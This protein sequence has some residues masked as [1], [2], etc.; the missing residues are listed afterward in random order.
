MTKILPNTFQTPNSYI[1]RAM[2]H[3]TDSELRC[4][5]FATRH[6][7]G[8]Q[9]KMTKRTARI[10]LSFFEQGYT[11][12][13]GTVYAGTGLNRAAIIKALEALVKYGFL[14]RVGKP[15]T[16]GQ[17]WRLNDTPHWDALEQRSAARQER[18]N[19]QTHPATR[20][21]QQ[22]RTGTLNDTS[23]VER[24][25]GTSNVPVSL[26]VPDRYVERTASG[27]SN[28]TESKP[29]QSQYKKNKNMSASDDAA[30]PAVT[31][32]SSTATHDD[33]TAATQPTNHMDADGSADTAPAPKRARPRNPL[34]DAIAET[35]GTT[36]GGW[37]GNM[38]S[39]MAGKGKANSAWAAC[40]FDPPA[41]PDEVRAFGVWA[42]A[43]N[44]DGQLPT[45]PA[46]IQRQFYA[47]RQ[48]QQA[49]APVRS[50]QLDFEAAKAAALLAER[51]S[52]LRVVSA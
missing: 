50:A 1:D 43:R 52:W 5:L 15:T 7:M 24:T 41:T 32:A 19:H 38:A 48:Q 16:A 9:D 17:Q 40:A 49:P 37:V 4:L 31:V 35:W 46:T 36:A 44:P 11:A 47:F 30:A 42:R 6:I 3:L 10:S 8:W 34:F 51:R 22:K 18:R 14:K 12:D 2:P 27:T 39:M 33:A 21:R 23:I 28:D 25:T 29:I 13:D 26:N 20:A 45:Q